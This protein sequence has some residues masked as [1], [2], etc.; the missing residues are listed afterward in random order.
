MPEGERTGIIVFYNTH[1]YTADN[2]T[3]WHGC[4]SAIKHN[5][6]KTVLYTTSPRLQNALE[7]AYLAKTK[8]TVAFTDETLQE[9]A[10]MKKLISSASLKIEDSDGPFPLRAI[11][12]RE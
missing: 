1:D 3:E 2:G 12:T 8:M 5:A 7:T 11:W 6:G 9:S 10:E 4:L